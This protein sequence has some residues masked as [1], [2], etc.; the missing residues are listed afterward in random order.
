M[1]SGSDSI[2]AIICFLP[3][4]ILISFLSLP[5]SWS[6]RAKL[7]LMIWTRKRY[8]NIAELFQS[9]G[10]TVPA[11][12]ERL[13]RISN[14]FRRWKPE[15]LQKGKKFYAPKSIWVPAIWICVIPFSIEYWKQRITEWETSGVFILCMT[16]RTGNRTRL[17]R[18]PTLSVP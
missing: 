18:S 8:A 3:P 11:E 16:S 13:K 15:N 6:K 4:I 7:M 12:I 2:G 5:F 10:K 9:L 1:W 17:K 14:Y